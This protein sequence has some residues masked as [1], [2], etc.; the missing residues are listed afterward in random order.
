MLGHE[1][2]LDHDR[3]AAGG[4]ESHDVPDVVD[5]VVRPRDEEAAEVDGG[6]AVLDDRSAEERPR[7]VV[8]TR[9]PLPGAADEV[10]AVDD[11]ARPHARTT[12]RCGPRCRHPQTS[13]CACWSNRARCQLCTPMIELTQPVDPHALPSL[14]TAS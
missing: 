12:T 5:A 2:V 8:A 1:D 9:G 10:T 13:S 7:R 11:G 14:R 3:V 6:A 4:L